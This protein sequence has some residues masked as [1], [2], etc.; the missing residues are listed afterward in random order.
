MVVR[1]KRGSANH[2]NSRVFVAHGLGSLPR[3]SS[4]QGAQVSDKRPKMTYAI[5]HLEA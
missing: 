5:L 4:T 2:G 3:S 1:E